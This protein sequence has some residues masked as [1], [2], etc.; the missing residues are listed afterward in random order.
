MLVVLNF[1]KTDRNIFEEI[2]SM[3]GIFAAILAIIIGIVT[4]FIGWK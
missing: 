2:K 4:L 1:K 3:E